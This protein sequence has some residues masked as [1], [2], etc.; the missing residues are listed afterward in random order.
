V[1]YKSGEVAMVGDKVRMGPHD[2]GVIV[3]SVDDGVYAPEYP[4][5]QWSYLGSGVMI[6]FES[7]GLVHISGNDPDLELL[8]RA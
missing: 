6:E 2:N 8:S 4:A 5:D 7:C 3:F 1:R